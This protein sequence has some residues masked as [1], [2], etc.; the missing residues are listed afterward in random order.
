L[1]VDVNKQ[2]TAPERDLALEQALGRPPVGM[3]AAGLGSVLVLGVLAG[4]AWL[5]FRPAEAAPQGPTALAAGESRSGPVA[6]RPDPALAAAVAF[7]AD[8]PS[9]DAEDTGTCRLAPSDPPLAAPADRARPEASGA[10]ALSTRL[11]DATRVRE[12]FQE[13]LAGSPDALAR[14]AGLVLG[15]RGDAAADGTGTDGCGTG[16]RGPEGDGRPACQ[17]VSKA[18]GKRGPAA[19]AVLTGEEAESLVEDW[20]AGHVPSRDALA[21]LAL[22]GS[23]PQVYALAWQACNAPRAKDPAGACQML[24][25]DQWARLDADN[26]VPWMEV[27]RLAQS[28][29]DRSTEAEAMFRVAK[30]R[31][32]DAGQGRLADAALK[33]VP[34]DVNAIDA[35][36]VATELLNFEGGTV[37]PGFAA[38]SLH[39]STE[40]LAD[41]NRLQ[42]CADIAETLVTR[43]RT[44]VDLTFGL[45]I[46]RRVG[47]PAARLEAVALERDA[48]VQALLQRM[49]PESAGATTCKAAR[50]QA[51][52]LQ[53]LASQGELNLARQA[54]RQSG[55]PPAELARQYRG[56][57]EG[58]QAR[59]QGAQAPAAAATALQP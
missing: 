19:S 9:S 58:R 45:G 57:F 46:G 10:Q 14:A 7:V 6:R 44:L 4:L 59:L 49:P 52:Y 47:W 42:Q 3:G 33:H 12:R 30:A 27:V 55:R 5:A 17:G 16:S 15:G 28:R 56:R 51:E 37:L 24:S 48:M 31:T 1:D 13:V 41:T 39:C 11:Q 29:G 38:V 36:Q 54:L 20:V 50:Q 18:V 22:A 8:G 35:V 25:A 23:S 21:R 43:G 53:A 34:A 26:A 32:V 40:R 2:G